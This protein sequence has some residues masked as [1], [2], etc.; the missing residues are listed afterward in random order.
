IELLTSRV[1]REL[2]DQ[3]KK[4]PADWLWMH[5]RWKPLRPH[6]LFALDQRAFFFPPGFDSKMLEPFRL[7]IQSP[8]TLTQAAQS[9]PAIK[10]IVRGRPDLHLTL[11]TPDDL[12]SFWQQ[13]NVT[14]ETLSFSRADS[15]MKVVSKRSE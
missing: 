2:E 15:I 11:L 9:L 14:D 4:S 7:L 1:N 10:A 12:T 3:I 5:H 13:A 6:F 8:D